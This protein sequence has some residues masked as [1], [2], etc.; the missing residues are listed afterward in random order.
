[1]GRSEL[2]QQ[3][4]RKGGEG[5]QSPIPRK[6]P[7][8][9][10]GC[11]RCGCRAPGVSRT[12]ACRSVPSQ[13]TSPAQVSYMS[14]AWSKC[15]GGKICFKTNRSLSQTNVSHP[16][17]SPGATQTDWDLDF[18][19]FS[20]ESS[21]PERA[22]WLGHLIRLAEDIPSLPPQSLMCKFCAP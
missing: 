6:A 12:T 16:S 21:D 2:K 5:L 22:P 7:A 4:P 20:P 17:A 15:G 14:R 13:A 3:M 19:L 11:A 18:S 9:P 1:M 8:A 10:L